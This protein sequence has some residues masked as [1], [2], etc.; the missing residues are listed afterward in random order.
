MYSL[1]VLALVHSLVQDNGISGVCT[2][3]WAV[4]SALWSLNIGFQWFRRVS[5]TRSLSV[6]MIIRGSCG[7]SFARIVACISALTFEVIWLIVR[8]VG[9]SSKKIPIGHQCPIQS[10][11]NN[12]SWQR[13]YG[14]PCFWCK[15]LIWYLPWSVLCRCQGKRTWLNNNRSGC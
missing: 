7:A 9:S 5:K 4:Q 11:S 1:R 15:G 14:G 8:N 13:S 6:D 12:E 10:Q 2:G 3:P